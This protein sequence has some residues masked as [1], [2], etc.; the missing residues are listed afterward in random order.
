MTEPRWTEHQ[1]LI[2]IRHRWPALNT[3]ILAADRFRLHRTS[4][5]S[6]LVAHY[7]FMSLFPL[8]LVFTAV[9][10]FVLDGNPDLQRRIIDSALG[11]A[12]VI[13]PQLEADPTR[14]TGN[15]PVLVIG[16]LTTLWAGLRAF[17]VLQTALDDIADVPLARRPSLLKVRTR[18][19]LGV[20]ILGSAQIG[21]AVLA[22]LGGTGG[23]PVLSRLLLLAGSIAVNATA[24]AATFRYLCSARPG[25]GAVRPGAIAAGL[26]FSVLQLVGTSLVA[27]AIAH[28]SPVYGAFASVIGLMTWLS[29]HAWVLLL[30]AE[31]NGVLVIRRQPEP[32]EPM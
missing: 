10:G 11:S 12:P 25:W 23:V 22:T 19:L 4:R 27:R 13:G 7:T 30:G 8:T 20:L 26:S 32:A 5:H 28:A 31:M 2:D 3:F 21:G 14:L 16:L 15:L 24:I 9:L 1:R 18:S 29:L 6:A 17:N